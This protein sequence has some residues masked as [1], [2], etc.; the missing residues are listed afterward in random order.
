[1]NGGKELVMD[2]P[3]F[4]LQIMFK[5]VH[6]LPVMC[7]NQVKFV[8]LENAAIYFRKISISLQNFNVDKLICF[9]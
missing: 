2:E 8:V 5:N 6:L 3:E 4:S 9:H 1:M 7:R